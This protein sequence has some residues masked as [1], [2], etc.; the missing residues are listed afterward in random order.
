MHYRKRKKKKFGWGFHA[1][2]QKNLFSFPT[3][4]MDGVRVDELIAIPGLPSNQI[5]YLLFFLLIF[6]SH[7]QLGDLSYSI[8][9]NP[10]STPSPVNTL[11]H[12]LDL[13]IKIH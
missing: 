13:M 3:D 12:L 4:E 5:P 7:V 2:I 9:P 1:F 10:Y 8:T 11:I 6:C